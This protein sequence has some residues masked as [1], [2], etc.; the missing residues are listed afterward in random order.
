VNERQ[1]SP[2]LEDTYDDDD[3]DSA[4][5]ALAMAAPWLALIAFIV[6]IGTVGYVLFVHPSATGGDDLAA[7]RSAAWQAIPEKR[8][9]PADWSLGSTDLNANGMTISIV[10]PAPA[11]QSSNQPIIYASVT[12]YGPTAATALEA[13]RKAAEDAGSEV[14]NRT[15]DGAAYDV[16]NPTTGSAT[17]LFR[18]GGLVGQVADAGTSDP[19]DLAKITKALA[20]AM[21]DGAAA[22]AAGAA[23]GGATGS[24]EPGSSE[25]VGSDEP[26]QS[27]FAPELEA[28]LPKSIPDTSSTA[29][30]QPDLP[31]TVIS[32]SATELLG[33]DPGSRALTAR[34]RTLGK[35]VNDLQ[36][37]Q[38]YD[39]T[40]AIDLSIIAFR[41]PG[42]DPAKFRAAIIETWLSATS[43]GVTVTQVTLGG[44]HVTKVDYGDGATVEY[45]Y[46]KGDTVIVIDTSDTAVA[47]SVAAALK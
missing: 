35:T 13:N 23:S 18:V 47:T 31:L 44:K 17:T 21:G 10:G 45:V 39:E 33:Q 15:A 22:G 34:I 12:C 36:V 25:P 14:T 40:G 29:S 11:D 16:N 30:P 42:V 7:C 19:S 32:N 9:L 46:A 28:L 3:V 6:A 27:P 38:A 37:A 5:G 2:D 26:S 24:G 41:L 1:L 43:E 4:R 20:I 8:N